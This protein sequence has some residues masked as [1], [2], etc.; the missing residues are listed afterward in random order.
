LGRSDICKAKGRWK[1]LRVIENM[2]VTIALKE[3]MMLGN[4]KQCFLRCSDC[5]RK[6]EEIQV[7]PTLPHHV[8]E[9]TLQVV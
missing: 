7:P 8:K 2:Y 3:I 5:G 6:Y 4:S 9:R 1:L